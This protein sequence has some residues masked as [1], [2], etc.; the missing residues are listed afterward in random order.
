MQSVSSCGELLR[1]MPRG[2]KKEAAGALRAVYQF[3]IS[4]AE[5]FTGH[6]DIADGQCVYV[7]GP[8][9]KPD[10]IVKSPAD[11]WLAVSKGELNGQT[12]FMAGKYKVEGDLAS[13]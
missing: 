4:G 9:H 5:T 6:L 1:M 3:E 12:A 10:V 7:D 13:S 11:V 8:H 2:F